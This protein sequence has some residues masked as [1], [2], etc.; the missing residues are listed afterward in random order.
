[1][2]YLKALVIGMGILIVVGIIFVAILI[3]KKMTPTSAETTH[4]S[5]TL[6]CNM[7][8]SS[9][10][11]DESAIAF[12]DKSKN[13]ILI[14]SRKNGQFLEEIILSFTQEGS[15]KNPRTLLGDQ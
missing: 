4:L 2:A 7:T 1:M 14:F 9:F 8:P 10:S 12:W 5:I 11:I 13:R 6:P 15:S 3:T